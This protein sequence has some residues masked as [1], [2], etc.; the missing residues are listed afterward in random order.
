MMGHSNHRT[1]FKRRSTT[2]FLR[3]LPG[4]WPHVSYRRPGTLEVIDD[5]TTLQR[6]YRSNLMGLLLKGEKLTR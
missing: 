5:E 3:W 1:G 6:Y 4:C 2:R